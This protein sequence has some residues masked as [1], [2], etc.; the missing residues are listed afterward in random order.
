MV[1]DARQIPPRRACGAQHLQR[2]CQGHVRCI[3]NELA[4]GVKCFV[5]RCYWVGGQFFP[6]FVAQVI[7]IFVIVS[8]LQIVPQPTIVG[9]ISP[10]CDLFYWASF[11]VL[12]H[13]DFAITYPILISLFWVVSLHFVVAG[14]I[15]SI[16]FCWCCGI[17]R[18][19]SVCVVTTVGGILSLSCC[20]HGSCDSLVWCV[21]VFTTSCS[22]CWRENTSVFAWS[23]FIMGFATREKI[24]SRMYMCYSTN[25]VS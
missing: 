7:I 20:R 24:R 12:A 19:G 16:R 23:C 21:G 8:F 9:V 6:V 3:L 2:A 4:S 15:G 18:G 13:F 5:M 17:L 1:L 11:P 14:F 10:A 25:S 22:S